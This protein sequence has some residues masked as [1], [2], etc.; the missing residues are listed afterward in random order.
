ML[1]LY[2]TDYRTLHIALFHLRIDCVSTAYRLRIDCVST[3]YHLRITLFWFRISLPFYLQSS[4]SFNSSPLQSL[5]L[6][7]RIALPAEQSIYLLHHQSTTSFKKSLLLSPLQCLEPLHLSNER[8]IDLS[9][10]TY[11]TDERTDESN[12]KFGTSK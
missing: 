6:W 2:V 1:L 5:Q 9:R 7:A 11:P 3:A 10:R 4:R 8:T 12:Q